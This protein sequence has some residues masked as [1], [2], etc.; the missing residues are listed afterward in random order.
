MQGQADLIAARLDAL[1]DHAQTHRPEWAR[2]LGDVPA[3]PVEAQQWRAQVRRIVAYRDRYDI[4]DAEPVPAR[5][6]Q[7]AQEA[8][9]ADA[10]DAYRQLRQEE[11]TDQP[12]DDV[13]D[14]DRSRRRTAA[15]SR[16]SELL[17]QVRQAPR[18]PAN[19]TLAERA[20]RLGGQRPSTQPRPDEPTR[21][22]D[23]SGPQ[24]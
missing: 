1:V 4:T 24:M 14:G 18:A 22:P 2:H 9:R 12:A 23:H 20:R 15:A 11:P 6:A 17:E 16:V 3:D 8:A 21:G 5:P 10:Y 13:A 7:G 19:E